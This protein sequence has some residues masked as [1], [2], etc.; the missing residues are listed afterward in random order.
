MQAAD[1]KIGKLECALE[2]RAFERAYSAYLGNSI[3]L[4]SRADGTE[5]LGPRSEEFSFLADGRRHALLEVG[6]VEWFEDLGPLGAVLVQRRSGNGFFVTL[7]DVALAHSPMLLRRMTISN[8]T[9]GPVHIARAAPLEWTLRGRTEVLAEAPGALVTRCAA[10]QGLFAAGAGLT[11][12]AESDTLDVGRLLAAEERT[13]QPG[14][15]WTL[16]M[17]C[18]AAFNGPIGASWFKL[19]GAMQ[20]AARQWEAWDRERE[21]LR[22][23]PEETEDPERN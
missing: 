21:A 8:L 22:R 5:W 14:E 17:V 7:E 16:P 2:N 9:H 13:L 1:A 4:V 3:S 23:S 19:Q 6:Y 20:E 11:P 12:E 18:L 15:V 10:E